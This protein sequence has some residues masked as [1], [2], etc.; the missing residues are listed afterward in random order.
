M[1]VKTMPISWSVETV[2]QTTST[3]I[4]L[5]ERAQSGA[6]E[7]LVIQALEQT[8]GRGRHGREWL[9][10]KGNLF[11]SCMLKP[12]CELH[13]IGQLS[14]VVGLAVGKAL[15]GFI[16]DKNALFL[17]WP[18]DILI[19][20]EKCAGILLN[21]QLTS[22]HEVSHLFVG[23]G[24]N[25]ETSPEEFGTDLRSHS[26]SDTDAKDVLDGIL[27]NIEACYTIW[28]VEGFEPIRQGWLDVAHKKGAA[29]SVKNHED[30]EEGYFHDIDEDG[31][32]IILD[33]AG[34][35]KT[36]SAGDVIL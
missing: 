18:N 29:L 22:V 19:D 9:S 12:Q 35:C 33:R 1:S 8:A 13:C 5:Q 10:Q 11:F 16:D 34:N 21:T 24:V 25:I 23:V 26:V 4:L 6:E 32:L 7:G 15:R 17:K 27:Q 28:N 20:G 2:E 30:V 14:L 31:S 36:I 3:Q